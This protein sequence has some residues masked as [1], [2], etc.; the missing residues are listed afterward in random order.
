MSLKTTITS[1]KTCNEISV[2]ENDFSNLTILIQN[3]L[4]EQDCSV[5]C[6]ENIEDAEDFIKIFRKKLSLFKKNS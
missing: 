5:F 4:D 1:E 3:P 6:F 2:F